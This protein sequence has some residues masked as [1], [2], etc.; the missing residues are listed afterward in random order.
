MLLHDRLATA[1]I[2]FLIDLSIIGWSIGSHKQAYPRKETPE[3][4]K[5]R[6]LERSQKA[7]GKFLKSLKTGGQKLLIRQ[8]RPLASCKSYWAL[9][10]SSIIE[11]G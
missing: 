3:P 9:A 6:I 1:Y 2:R 7:F 11:L 10:S 8:R 4:K 5:P